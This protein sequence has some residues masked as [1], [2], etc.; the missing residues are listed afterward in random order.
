MREGRVEVLFNGSW[1]S[2]CGKNWNQYTGQVVCRQIGYFSLNESRLST[3]FWEGTSNVILND[4]ICYGTEQNIGECT[5]NAGPNTC[6]H[7]QDAGVVCN[8]LSRIEF[9]LSII[10]S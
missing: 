8:G 1:V 9:G 7:D 4:I 6:S 2:V 10:T 5:I 3:Y